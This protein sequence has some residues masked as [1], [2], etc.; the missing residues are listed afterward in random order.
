[1]SWYKISQNL[2]EI[3]SIARTVRMQMEQKHNS[4]DL[5]SLCHE[6]SIILAKKLK[7]MGYISA[8]EVRGSVY[9]DNPDQEFYSDWDVDMFENEEKMKEEMKY[10]THHWVEI[11]N[12]VVDITADQ[13]NDELD[14]DEFPKVYVEL[15]ENADR[16]QTGID[17]Y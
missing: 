8:T 5:R 7:K 12:I 15:K 13:F 4:E 14:E 3:R 17:W 10:A 9:I 6:I 1:M 2:A 11:G 16:Y